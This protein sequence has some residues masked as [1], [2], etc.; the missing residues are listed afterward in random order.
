MFFFFWKLPLRSGKAYK[1]SWILM[2]SFVYSTINVSCIPSLLTNCSFKSLMMRIT[3][4]EQYKKIEEPWILL[5]N[6]FPPPPS[7]FFFFIHLL[8][9]WRAI[10]DKHS[11]VEFILHWKMKY[12]FSRIIHENELPYYLFISIWL[13]R[14]LTFTYSIAFL[15]G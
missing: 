13:G 15:S 10:E 9:V 7:I 11:F 12:L 6:K 5:T 1:T 4:S 8:K 14:T 2:K 3:I